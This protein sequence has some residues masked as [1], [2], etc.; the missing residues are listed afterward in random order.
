MLTIS[1]CRSGPLAVQSGILAPNGIE[2]DQD[3]SAFVSDL[4]KTRLDRKIPE[5]RGLLLSLDWSWSK[6]VFRL[7][8]QNISQL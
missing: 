6:P 5:D 4:S 1:V 8:T 7:N 2:R 3:W